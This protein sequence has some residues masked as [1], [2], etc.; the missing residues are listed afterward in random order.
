MTETTSI[1]YFDTGYKML[2]F[3]EADADLYIKR[4]EVPDAK[5]K[6]FDDG[7]IDINALVAE[8]G[9]DE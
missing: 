9:S 5:M 3:H 1:L 8:F 6:D 2:W 7:L 4:M